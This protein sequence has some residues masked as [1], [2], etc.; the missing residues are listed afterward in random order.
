MRHERTGARSSEVVTAGAD[1]KVEERN[2]HAECTRECR[3]N[4]DEAKEQI[5]KQCGRKVQERRDANVSEKA[6]FGK[7]THAMRIQTC[8]KR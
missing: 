2:E 6:N 1:A 4:S 7:A 8:A 3:G 5:E